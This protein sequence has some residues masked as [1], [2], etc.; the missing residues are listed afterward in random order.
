M[1]KMYSK[2]NLPT[3]YGDF[4]IYTFINDE[5]KDH[6]VLVR[7]SVEGKEGVPLR[8]HSECLTGDVFSSKRCDC[9]DQLVQS[10]KYLANSEFGMLI[11]LRQEGRGIGLLDKIK[12]YS[13]QEQGLDT[14]E[15]NLALGLPVDGRDYGY[16]VNVL[17]YFKIKSVKLMSNN[18]EKF[19]Y[20]R[21]KGI[22]V[23]ERIPVLSEPTFHDAFYLETKKI[24]LGHQI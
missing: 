18:P 15:A 13:L 2:A 10:L 24:K 16:V 12:A 9:H 3:S 19:E 17:N 22:N 20:L 5:G 7:G 4:V 11:Y 23:I 1:F 21:D 6:A 14:V 8:I